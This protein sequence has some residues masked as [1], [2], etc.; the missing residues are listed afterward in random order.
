MVESGN[1]EVGKV[2]V[3]I[4]GADGSRS[5]VQCELMEFE[6]SDHGAILGRL[7]I[8][9]QR[10]ERVSWGLPPRDP[11][12]EEPPAKVRVVID[13]GTAAGQEI[14]VASERFEVIAW[15]IGLHV[16]DRVDAVLG[17]IDQRRML[18]PWHAVREYERVSASARR[19]TSE[20]LLRPRPDA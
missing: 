18:V 4:V 7:V 9:W 12:L 10:I 11:D 14:V 5:A 8:P 20:D 3:T 13:D 15:A 17:T 19:A 2:T 16:D 1:G 6:Q